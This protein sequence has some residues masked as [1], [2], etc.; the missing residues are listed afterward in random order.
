[1][2]PQTLGGI[3]MIFIAGVGFWFKSHDE[4]D[5]ET[6]FRDQTK[7]DFEKINAKIEALEKSKADASDLKEIGDRQRENYQRQRD[8]N[9][10]TNANIESVADWMHEQIGYQKA[11]EQKHK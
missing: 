5:A 4:W 6:K 10:K 11:M 7:A 1:M 2:N 9:D 3:L 8:L